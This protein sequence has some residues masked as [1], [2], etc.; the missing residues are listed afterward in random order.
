[1]TDPG[2]GSETALSRWIAELTPLAFVA[3]LCFR[4]IG[5][6]IMVPIAEELA[7]RGYLYRV[8]IARPFE[9]VDL[10]AFSMRALIV[11]SVLFGMMHDRWMAAALA[12]ALYALLMCWR[13]RL[14]D[15]ITAHMTTN[16]VIFAWAVATGQWSL[17]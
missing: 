6:I 14:S 3:W 15:A 2:V 17:L 8:V 9:S 1:V 5:T 16:A 10:K 13:G 11:S 4:G 12:G 7:F